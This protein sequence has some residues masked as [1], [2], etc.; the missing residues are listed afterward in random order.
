MVLLVSLLQTGMLDIKDPSG[1]SSIPHS[2]RY[3]LDIRGPGG[4]SN[5]PP[6]NRYVLDIRGPGGP[7]SIPPSNR[8]VGY[9]GPWWSF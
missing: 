5:I 3:V 4:P 1:P 6:S 8:Y 2:I 7:S 9:Q